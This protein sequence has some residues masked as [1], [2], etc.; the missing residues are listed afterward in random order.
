MSPV[1]VGHGEI[2][3]V[4]AA[5]RIVTTEAEHDVS[6]ATQVVSLKFWKEARCLHQT[7]LRAKAQ[8]EYKQA[9]TTKLISAEDHHL[10]EDML[11]TK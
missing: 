10:Q 1:Y 11:M 9:M 7:N 8:F 4:S 6:L 5:L 3:V 2:A